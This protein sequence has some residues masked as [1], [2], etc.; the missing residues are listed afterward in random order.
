MKFGNILHFRCCQSQYSGGFK[1]LTS[2]DPNIKTLKKLDENNI[3]KLNDKLLTFQSKYL[4]KQHYKQRLNLS[5]RG[6]I[7]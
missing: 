5:T 7:L 1:I 6:F 2:V 3:K 4:Y